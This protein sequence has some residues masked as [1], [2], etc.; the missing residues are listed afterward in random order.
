MFALSKVIGISKDGKRAAILIRDHIH[1]EKRTGRCGSADEAFTLRFEYNDTDDS[2]RIIAVDAERY[3]NLR[4]HW[5]VT[6]DELMLQYE[7]IQRD[8]PGKIHEELLPIA[9]RLWSEKLRDLSDATKKKEALNR[10]SV[11]C[12]SS[13]AYDHEGVPIE[14]P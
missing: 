10:P 7:R 9:K 14:E 6:N 13:D 12:E 5:F 8:V 4:P 3:K 1:G 11:M 2:D